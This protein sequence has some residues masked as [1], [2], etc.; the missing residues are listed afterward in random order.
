VTEDH[1]DSRRS[2]RPRFDSIGPGAAVGTAGAALW[3]SAEGAAGRVASFWNE[4]PIPDWLIPASVVLMVVGALLVAAPLVRI[5][6]GR[7]AGMR[8]P[9]RRWEVLM[10][11]ALA[12]PP[13]VVAV[14]A[15]Q[16]DYRWQPL[17]LLI[18]VP[19]VLRLLRRL[20]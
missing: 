5:A 4:Q 10:L 16:S 7:T 20:G 11:V 13:I 18:G 12:G 9:S 14:T 15:T 19:F 3:F 2:W 6:S 17:A 1:P 8:E